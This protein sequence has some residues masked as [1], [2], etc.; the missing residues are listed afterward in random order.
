MIFLKLSLICFLVTFSLIQ[1][2]FCKMKKQ[3]N[4]FN[5]TKSFV[6]GGAVGPPKN[7]RTPKRMKEIADSGIDV[8]ILLG[9]IP[10]VKETI[11]Y[12]D[13]AHT[14]GIKVLP[15]DK[16]CYSAFMG[17]QNDV[18]ASEKSIK[19]IVKDYS[20]HPALFAYSI[21]DEPSYKQ[22]ENLAK[23]LRLLEKND[24][25]HFGF[26][27]LFP[28]YASTA[29]LGCPNFKEHVK[30]YVDIVKP[31]VLCYDH[32]SLRVNKS[33]SGWFNDLEIIREE[34]RRVK[35]PFWI[36]VLSEGIKK[37]LRVP[38][39]AEILW[40]ANSALAYGARGI[41]W[42]CYWTPQPHTEAHHNAMIDLKGNK[43]PLYDYVREEN[44]FLKD[45]G[46]KLLSW[47]NS[48]IQRYVKSKPVSGGNSPVVKP[49]GKNLNLTLGT[50]KKEN[51]VRIVCVND[52]VD[53]LAAFTFVTNPNYK[54]SKV[55]ASIDAAKSKE[56]NI[57]LKLKPGGCIVLEYIRNAK[58][59]KGAMNSRLK[60]D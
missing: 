26:I 16:R 1:N 51:R 55:V 27:N 8:I 57:E 33:D 20:D 48:Y 21:Y 32:Y 42:F 31:T 13:V 50:F 39:R 30:S 14:A 37:Y 56:K 58:V 15:P 28:G 54:F 40:Q 12:M 60:N 4:I 59:A 23:V 7:L 11:E 25:N 43:T 47:D 22:F 36:Y 34:S 44:I 10:T 3:N 9:G 49:V 17:G 29:A 45:A 19:A 35:T 24:K 46:N 5:A 53:K 52:N 18:D 2:S 6:I 41:L 38:T